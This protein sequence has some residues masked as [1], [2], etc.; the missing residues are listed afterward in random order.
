MIDHSQET[1]VPLGEAGHY[2]PHRGDG[3]ALHRSTLQRWTRRGICG[4][5][6]ETLRVGG[7]VYTSVEALGRFL[8]KTN[9][10]AASRSS[11]AVPEQPSPRVPRGAA[12][13]KG[14]AR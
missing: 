6:L 12:T 7:I 3:R 10:A 14:G 1:V 8:E 11:E 4:V 9:L 13:P 5:R 2:L